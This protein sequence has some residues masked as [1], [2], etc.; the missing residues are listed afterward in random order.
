MNIY[1]NVTLPKNMFCKL[2]FAPE[3]FFFNSANCSPMVSSGGWGCHHKEIAGGF[4]EDREKRRGQFCNSQDFGRLRKCGNCR[5][6]WSK[7]T[8]YHKNYLDY[9]GK[10]AS[11]SILVTLAIIATLDTR[12]ENLHTLKCQVITLFLLKQYRW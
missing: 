10:F 3:L 7:I 2:Y 12:A 6:W 8:H 1:K 9:T 11:L 4:E 5:C